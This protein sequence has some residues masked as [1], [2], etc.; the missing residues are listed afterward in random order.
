MASGRSP[1]PSS[2]RSR[3]VERHAAQMPHRL[4]PQVAQRARHHC[5]YCLAPEAL[6]PG[7]FEVAHIEPRAR[8]GSDELHNLALACWPCNRRKGQTTYVVEVVDEQIV[9]VP[10]F[11][12]RLDDWDSH[13][14][15]VDTDEGIQIVGQ[16][17]TGRAT[18]QQIGMNDPHMVGARVQW[19]I[20]D[21][22]PP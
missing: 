7:R 13:F 1:A 18:V 10:L 3:K 8:G 19:A 2:L 6:S 20:L 5:E 16:T 22:F 17:S 11:N 4:Y 9:V 21:K 12:P 14:A 15:L